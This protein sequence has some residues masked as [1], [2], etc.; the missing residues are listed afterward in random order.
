MLSKK[1]G[2]KWGDRRLSGN[3]EPWL[4]VNLSLVFA[5]LGQ[6]YVGK[7]VRGYVLL[8]CQVSIVTIGCWLVLAPSGDATVGQGLLV[9]FL[10]IHMWNLY[11]AHRCAR[12]M[13]NVEYERAR[14]EAADPWLAVLFTRICPGIGHLYTG[15]WLIGTILTL[16]TVTFM[17]GSRIVSEYSY[18][19]DVVVSGYQ[20]IAMYHA[21]GTAP[22][23]REASR[24]SIALF[25]MA[26]VLIGVTY[27]AGESVIR[28]RYVM[29]ANVVSGSME[30]VLQM[31]DR[32]LVDKRIASYKRGDVVLFRMPLNAS[33]F[34]KERVSIKRV[35][36][37]GG[38]AVEVREDGIYIDGDRMIR[39]YL[40]VKYTRYSP[41][42]EFGREGMEF[43][44]PQR[45]YFLMGDNHEHSFDSRHLGAIPMVDIIGKAYKVYWPPSHV[46]V[47][48]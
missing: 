16:L 43:N 10:A 42:G 4:A 3:K 41:M 32:I 34:S 27:D 28:E 11:D 31:G 30:P 25:A 5:G 23:R 1:N 17:F 13:N 38:E 24:T 7:D 6:L 39:K 8:T 12:V 35:I 46:G 45:T 20:G 29:S 2:N 44:V 33:V 36:A 40:A 21:Y 48:E 47:I 15:R 37:V 18:W 22:Y 19:I 14:R 9:L 26:M